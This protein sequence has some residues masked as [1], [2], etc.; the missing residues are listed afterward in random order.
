LVTEI[1]KITELK[2]GFPN[3]YK[4]TD[5]KSKKIAQVL[6]LKVYWIKPLLNVKKICASAFP[7]GLLK[8]TLLNVFLTINW[9]KPLVNAKINL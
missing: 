3:G 2:K 7:N 5:T 9:A 8:K 4:K 1:K 6:F